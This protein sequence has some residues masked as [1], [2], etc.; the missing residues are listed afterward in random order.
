MIMSTI[1]YDQDFYKDFIPNKEEIIGNLEQAIID[2]RESEKTC[3]S[4]R[5]A[6]TV[7]IE[8]EINENNDPGVS[9]IA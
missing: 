5:V 8:I 9:V 7:E 2:I 4:F 3:F 6:G 1:V